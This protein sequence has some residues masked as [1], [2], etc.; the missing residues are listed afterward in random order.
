MSLYSGEEKQVHVLMLDQ[1]RGHWSVECTPDIAPLGRP[2]KAEGLGLGYSKPF[3]S[4]G[5][6]GPTIPPPIQDINFF[7][8]KSGFDKT[9]DD[10]V[11]RVSMD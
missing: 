3:R 8:Y 2:K 9:S 4:L 7:E 11:A 5:I 1:E 6:H 10:R